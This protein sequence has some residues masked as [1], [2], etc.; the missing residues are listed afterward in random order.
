MDTRTFIIA[1]NGRLKWWLHHTLEDLSPE[2]LHYRTPLIDDRPIAE[3]A[4][5]AAVI[6]HR[7][8][9]RQNDV[10]LRHLDGRLAHRQ[11]RVN[12]LD[13]RVYLVMDGGSEPPIWF[14][15]IEKPRWAIARLAELARHQWLSVTI[16]NVHEH[17][18]YHPFRCV[19]LFVNVQ[20]ACHVIPNPVEP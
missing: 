8:T 2:Q 17:D 16:Q 11:E 10:E 1:T 9:D 3:V 12:R 4:M 14:P 5:H 6:F 18:V 15:S 20:Q 7:G 13:M 19:A